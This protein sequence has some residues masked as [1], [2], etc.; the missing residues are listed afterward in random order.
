M[1]ITPEPK[2]GRY[3]DSCYTAYEATKHPKTGWWLRKAG[4]LFPAFS[5]PDFP[6]AVNAGLFIFQPETP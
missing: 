3:R 1:S 6:A 5:K 2:P 4:S